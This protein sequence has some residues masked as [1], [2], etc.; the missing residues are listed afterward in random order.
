[1]LDTLGDSLVHLTQGSKVRKIDERFEALR[2]EVE[3]FEFGLSGMERGTGRLKGR[4]NGT[5]DLNTSSRKFV[6]S[7]TFQWIVCASDLGKD[8]EDLSRSI[9]ALGLLESGMTDPLNQF[10]ERLDSFSD[11]LTHLVRPPPLYSV[12]F[13]SFN[14]LTADPICFPRQSSSPLP[15]LQA[16]LHSLQNYAQQ[17]HSLLALRAQKQL[18]VEILTEYLSSIVLERDR[19]SALVENG[20]AGGGAGGGAVGVGGWAREK[21]E[22]LR[23]RDDV[24]SRRVRMGVLDGKIAEVCLVSSAPPPTV[25]RELTSIPSSRSQLQDAVLS[26]HQTSERFSTAT[27]AEHGS[28]EEIKKSEMKDL[29]GGFVDGQVELYRK[30]VEDWDRVIPR[31]ENVRV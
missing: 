21:V 30:A 15:P 19:L 1:M 23:G 10:A 16:H 9:R 27:L 29:L 18:D 24:H 12:L 28:F 11:V 3:R 31:L 4:T 5:S 25:L 13:L 17:H 14:C 7:L 26:S 20:G 22:R 2:E 6:R 8:Y